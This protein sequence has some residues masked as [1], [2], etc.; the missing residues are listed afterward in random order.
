VLDV[1]DT[2]GFGTNFAYSYG[3][4]DIEK[5]PLLSQFAMPFHLKSSTEKGLSESKALQ[6][7]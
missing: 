1:V 5:L 6:E 4:E 3:P 7:R 2:Q